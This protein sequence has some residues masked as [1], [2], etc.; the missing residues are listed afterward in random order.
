MI[1]E[2]VAKNKTRALV[3]IGQELA[4]LSSHPV[5]GIVTMVPTK[6]DQPQH[7]LHQQPNEDHA[8][9]Y[10]CKTCVR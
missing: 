7:Q 10:L 3:R 9:L 5:K 6:Y 1:S 8:P 4:N 2:V